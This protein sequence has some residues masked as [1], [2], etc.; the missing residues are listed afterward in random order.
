MNLLANGAIALQL[1][2]QTIKPKACS[3]IIA[4]LS[5]ALVHTLLGAAQIDRS[6]NTTGAE[7]SPMAKFIQA[8][9]FWLDCLTQKNFS[10]AGC[11]RKTYT[12]LGG[13]SEIEQKLSL[14]LEP[15]EVGSSSDLV[16]QEY[17]IGNSTKIE[18]LNSLV[19]VG[20]NAANQGSVQLENGQSINHT[21]TSTQLSSKPNSELDSTANFT[22]TNNHP[23]ELKTATPTN[24]IQL[25]QPLQTYANVS[26]LLQQYYTWHLNQQEFKQLRQQ[27]S[28]SAMQNHLTKLNQK[29]DSFYRSPPANPRASRYF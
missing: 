22:A 24:S 23:P 6:L 25:T 3:V 29:L 13:I 20:A 16:S 21:T 27:I 18:P 26:D 2:P 28:S 11:D 5:S 15:S 19:G 14:A 1:I 4:A 8:W 12:V 17:L 10:P 9:Q 7:R